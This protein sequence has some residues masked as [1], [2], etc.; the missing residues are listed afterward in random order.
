[1][2]LGHSLFPSRDSHVS[3]KGEELTHCPS[4]ESSGMKGF[5]FCENRVPL[6]LADASA[7]I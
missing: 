4:P 6:G 2:A 1:M 3:R 7:P 5:R